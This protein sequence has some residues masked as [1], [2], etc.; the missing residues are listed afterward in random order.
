MDYRRC[1]ARRSTASHLVVVGLVGWLAIRIVSVALEV[2]S[3]DHMMAFL[4]ASP[5]SSWSLSL[6]PSVGN[7]RNK[8]E[9]ASAVAGVVR[10][11]LLESRGPALREKCQRRGLQVDE[12]EY[13]DVWDQTFEE[14]ALDVRE[15]LITDANLFFIGPDVESYEDSIR[16]VAEALNYTQLPFV[17]D[18]LRG[19]TELVD[20]VEKVFSVPPLLNI[21]RWPWAVMRHGLV[22]WIDPDSHDQ[23]DVNTRD[24]V[25]KLKFPRKKSAFGPDKPPNLLDPSAELPGDPIDMWMEAD[26]H[27]DLRNLDK[28]KNNAA[29]LILASIINSILDSPPKWRGWFKAAK[30]RGTIP[31][32]YET[33][34]ETR[35]DFHSNGV[36][37]RLNRLLKA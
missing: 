36:S 14:L 15:L 21:Q 8:L 20:N 13:I 3:E 35:R 2:M 16:A 11:A 29:N 34:L 37:P 25:R 12:D 24:R 18:D 10:Q 32:W 1:R 27:V 9:G 19:A 23:W 22:I 6:A 17:Y 7:Q 4:R 28:T 30:I 26:V 31:S 5:V 33:P